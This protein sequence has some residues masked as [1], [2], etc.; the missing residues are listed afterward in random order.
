MLWNNTTIF[1]EQVFL[2]CRA[3]AICDA[4]NGAGIKDFETLMELS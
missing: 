2:N 3:Q 4:S 1:Q